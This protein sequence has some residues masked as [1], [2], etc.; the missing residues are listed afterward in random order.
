MMYCYQ[1]QETAKNTGCTIAGVCGKK[2]TTAAKMD[3][4]LFVTRGVAIAADILRRNQATPP[5]EVDAFV[6]D[7]LFTT[8]TNA[9]FDEEAITAKMKQGLLIRNKLIRMVEKH[10][11]ALPDCE[12][13]NW[14]GNNLEETATRVGVLRESDKDLRSLKELITYGLKGMAAYLQH[15]RVLDYEDADIDAFIQRTLADMVVNHPNV[16]HLIDLV[17]ETGSYGIRAM[18]LLDEANSQTYGHPEI[19]TVQTHVGYRPGILVSGHDLADLEMLLQQCERQGVDVYTHGEMLPAHYYPRLRKYSHLVSNYGGAWWRQRDDFAHFH[20]P[21]LFTS[22]CIV[23][24]IPDSDYAARIFTT[25]S[26]GYPGSRHI[27]TDADGSKDFSPI[28]NMAKHCQ[29]PDNLPIYPEEETATITGGF[30]HHQ[31]DLL[32]NSVVEAIQKGKIRQVVV[33]AGCDGRMKSRTYYTDFARQLPHDTIILTAGCAKYRYHRLNLGSI[34]GIPRVLDAGQCNDSYSLA[35]IAIKLQALIGADDIND[36]PIIYNIA[37]Y[38][39]KAVIVLLALLSLGVKHIRLGPTLPAFLS[40]NVLQYLIDT[41]DICTINS[42]E[43]DL[44]QTT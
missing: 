29:P 5:P 30:A 39:Q 23:P 36:L 38:E 40:P 37:W 27:D 1:C 28:I 15:A 20:G 42:P 32:A 26:A 43:E 2:A 13:L 6:D 10:R 21:I 25:G 12:E 33:M 18:A 11:L 44:K 31:F 14:N 8:I 34:D 4:L 7:A 35:R 41:F 22:N 19:T 24:P 16:K 3:L 9:N 17:K